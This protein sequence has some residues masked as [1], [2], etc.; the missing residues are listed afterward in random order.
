MPS[1]ILQKVGATLYGFVQIKAGHAP[2]RT[3]HEPVG[4]GEHYGRFEECLHQP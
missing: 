2:G 3:A 1:E 4:L